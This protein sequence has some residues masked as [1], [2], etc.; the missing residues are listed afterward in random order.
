M[1]TYNTA[2][3]DKPRV[4]ATLRYAALR[5]YGLLPT[6]ARWTPSHAVGP[7]AVTRT[8]SAR[9]KGQP[10]PPTTYSELLPE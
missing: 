3:Q 9:G 1:V 4:D 5:N 6:T 7:R 2:E 10:E 8:S